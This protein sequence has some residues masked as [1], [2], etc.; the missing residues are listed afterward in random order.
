MKRILILSNTAALPN[1]NASALRISS[2]VDA[3]IYSGFECVVV[4]QSKDDEGT[5]TK[6]K[7]GYYLYSIYCFKKSNS[8]KNKIYTFLKP[9]KKILNA[10]SF[11]KEK[12]GPFDSVLIYQQLPNSITKKIIKICKR[13]NVKL[14]FDIVTL[15]DPSF[16]L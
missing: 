6:I 2:I 3:L 7:E 4:G 11:L 14:Y 1:Q 10:Y 9:D 12:F 8:K 15:T 16:A 5:L 13:E